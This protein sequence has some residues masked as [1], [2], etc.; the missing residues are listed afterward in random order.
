M[1]S[2]PPREATRFSTPSVAPNCCDYLALCLGQ[3]LR[4][5]HHCLTIRSPRPLL[6]QVRHALAAQP[7]L[8]AA[9]RAL[10]NL[11]HCPAFQRLDLDLRSQRR[12][13]ED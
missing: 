7:E 4:H 8:L 12:L 6:V 1:S 9:L 2:R 11:Q 13:R 10:G 5:L 3:L